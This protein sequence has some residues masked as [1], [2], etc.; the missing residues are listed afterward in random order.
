[1]TGFTIPTITTPR[2]TLRAAKLE[3]FDSFAAFL[4]SEHSRYM[5]GPVSRDRA[6]NWFTGD[7]AG[8]TLQGHG[9]LMI[10]H[11]GVVIGQVAISQPPW[12][13]EVELGWLI[14]PAHMGR[15][16]ATEAAAALRDWAWEHTRI[17]TLVSYIAPNNAA[18]RAL[19]EKLGAV[20]DPTAARPDGEGPEDCVVYRHPLPDQA[21]FAPDASADF[22]GRPEASA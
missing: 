21:G 11:A 17:P 19:A 6:W 14:Y 12:F 5:D 10:E 4:A 20:I 3:E 2:L 18:S 9:G 16:Y 15:G 1:M 22:G 13:P 8:W 7:I